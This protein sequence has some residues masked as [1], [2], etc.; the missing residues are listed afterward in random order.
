MKIFAHKL[1][2][3]SVSVH[4]VT[5]FHNFHAQ[6]CKKNRFDHVTAPY[7]LRPTSQNLPIPYRTK[8]TRPFHTTLHLRNVY[9]ITKPPYHAETGCPI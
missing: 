4:E 7:L 6:R 3:L 9:K 8:S 2:E 5:Q 1:V